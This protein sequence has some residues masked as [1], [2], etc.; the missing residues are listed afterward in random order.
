M[1]K[2]ISLF[3]LLALTLIQEAFPQESINLLVRISTEKYPEVRA[4]QLETA[5]AQREL[6]YQKA[7]ITPQLNAS[8]QANYA[9]ANNI[10]GMFMP[11]QVLPISGPPSLENSAQ[12]VYGSAAALLLNWSPLTFGKRQS[13]VNTAQAELEFSKANEELAILDHQIKFIHAYLDFWAMTAKVNALEKNMERYRFNLELS[14]SLVI[15]GLRPG[16][17]SSQFN[18]LFIKSKLELLQGQREMESYRT[19]VRELL[20]DDDVTIPVDQ[21]L[22]NQTARLPSST[23]TLHP[24]IQSSQQQTAIAQYQKTQISRSLLP[25]LNF[26]GTGFARGSAILA[27]GTF[28][29]PT[30]GLSFSR[31]N[32][33]LG[34]QVTVPVFQFAQTR[35]RIKRQDYL[36]EASKAREETIYRGLEKDR[37]VAQVTF[38]KA[39]ET[40]E[41]APDYVQA[42][43]YSFDALQ[44]RYD[45]G[46]INMAELLQGQA[47][48]AEAEAEVIKAKAEMWKALLYQA[49]VQGEISVFTQNFE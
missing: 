40:A 15:N 4:R 44:A 45:A 39:L 23:N 47:T 8:Y 38:D 25:D 2:T 11:G 36:V 6:S 14:R 9:T 31:Y 16:V 20:G 43:Q 22:G 7:D 19:L 32:Y 33:G 13:R 5:A 41:L 26:W 34:F 3:F 28:E 27:D 37:I 24:L 12:M 48:L 21:R 42:A 29:A 30:E 10:T 35:Q 18:S 17:D 46:L 49:A 1:H